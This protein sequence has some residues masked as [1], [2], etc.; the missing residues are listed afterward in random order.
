MFRKPIGIKQP[1]VL[2]VTFDDAKTSTDKIEMAVAK[3]GHDKPNHK[4]TE[5]VYKKLPGC[6]KYERGE[7]NKDSHESHQH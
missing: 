5:D 7:K 4:A 2:E 3:A 1:K 6:C